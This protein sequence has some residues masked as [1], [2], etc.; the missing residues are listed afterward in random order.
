MWVKKPRPATADLPNRSTPGGAVADAIKNVV[1]RLGHT[2][3]F[4]LN[5]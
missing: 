2:N 4:I 1:S 5:A 3:C